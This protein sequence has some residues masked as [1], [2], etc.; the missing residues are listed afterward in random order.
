MTAMR[1]R[2]THIQGQREGQ[3]P[4]LHGL[5]CEEALG[6]GAV[7][8]EGGASLF[9]CLFYSIAFRRS[10]QQAVLHLVGG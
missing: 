7:G 3:Q 4:M 9:T 6:Q 5:T 10:I 2:C 8:N 1:L